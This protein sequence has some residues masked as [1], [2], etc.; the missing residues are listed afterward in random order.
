[1]TAFKPVKFGKYILLD[2]VAT[3]GMAEL[4]RA[5][6]TGV[7]GFEKLI[8]IK[9]ILP[10]LTSENALVSSFIDEA[11]LAAFLQHPNIVQI[12]DFG[13]MEGAY[14]L[15]MEYLI[16]K[17]LKFVIEKA[18]EA[19][20][21]ICLEDA[22]LITTQICNGLF[23]AHNLKDFHGKSLNLI[24]RDIGPQNIFITYDGQVKIIDFGIAKAANQS[25]V[26]QTDL[27]KGKVAY[28]SPE[29][30]RG[31]DIDHRSDIFSI[32]IILYELVTHKRMFVGDT[33]Q[34]YNKVCEMDFEPPENSVHNL[35]PI[36]YEILNKAL[37]EN[38]EQ[39]YGSAEEMGSDLEKCLSQLSDQSTTRNISQYMK[40]VLGKEADAEERAMRESVL[41]DPV[42][43]TGAEEEIGFDDEATKVLD[44]SEITE[45]PERK[46]GM[47]AALALVLIV[48]SI[49]FTWV[50]FKK[51]IETLNEGEK[52]LEEKHFTEAILFFE[53]L[54]A[55]D[56]SV[57]A[58]VTGP[59]SM[60]LR[61]QAAK[62]MER[63]EPE[64]AKLLLL[65][66]EGTNPDDAKGHYMLG[67]IYA[68]EKDFQNAILSYKNAI[69]LDSNMARAHFNLGYIYYVV[70][71]DYIRAQEMYE[72][73]VRLSPDFLDDALYMLALSQ[74]KLGKDRESIKNL[75]RALNINPD[76]KQAKTS[77]D[78]LKKL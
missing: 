55:K 23:Y 24:H 38:P 65:K 66:S 78:R 71:K 44:T 40:G 10:H 11:K 18:K 67:R 33:Y 30:A 1:M 54:L 21:P 68:D 49:A 48:L 53:D 3:G 9:K 7:K 73:T 35:P 34:I 14:F 72:H 45:R 31:K 8:A 28:M 36:L 22:I 61:K 56:P 76:N 41:F 26:T 59:Y 43:V 60:A 50:E 70:K 25:T 77:L 58:Q 75:E 62:L 63:N 37:S 17:D 20:N 47:Y 39:R 32:G 46:A 42:E 5:K 2:K 4:Y 57:K 52:L 74:K 6:I 19:N 16:G 29:Q 51:P 13:S 15:A 64:K 27:I 12:Y 69:E